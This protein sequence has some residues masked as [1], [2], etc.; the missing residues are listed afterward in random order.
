MTG[1]VSCDVETK[2][3]LVV[4]VL[5]CVLGMF[6]AVEFVECMTVTDVVTLENDESTV[7]DDEKGMKLSSVMLLWLEFVLTSTSL[8]NTGSPFSMHSE[9]SEGLLPLSSISS[10]F[11]KSSLLLL[12]LLLLTGLTDAGL[13]DGGA[14]G[15]SANVTF[16][17]HS[18]SELVLLQQLLHMLLLRLSC[19]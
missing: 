4:K 9:R 6:V 17:E 15:S 13:D 11:M 1:D 16:L 10:D 12:L 7:T 5:R 8:E 19:C 14:V 2:E 3:F 18:P